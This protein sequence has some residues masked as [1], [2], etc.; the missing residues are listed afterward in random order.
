MCEKNFEGVWSS[1]GKV[2]YTDLTPNSENESIY[3]DQYIILKINKIDNNIYFISFIDKNKPTN[4]IFN[5]TA[6]QSTEN[7][8]LLQS[9]TSGLDNFYFTEHDSETLNV[10]YTTPV[11]NNKCQSAVFKFH[12]I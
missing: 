1:I 4:N 12:R 5:C 6:T 10:N 3:V 9:S 7:K 11:S 8:W 2:Y